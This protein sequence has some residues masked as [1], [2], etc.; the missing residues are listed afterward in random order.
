[1][2]EMTV[3]MTTPSRETLKKEMRYML[4]CYADRKSLFALNTVRVQKWLL[5]EA[6]ELLCDSKSTVS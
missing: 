4:K 3:T 6:A 1:M 5:S 2:K